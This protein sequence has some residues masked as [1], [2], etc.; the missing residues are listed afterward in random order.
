M[1][2]KQLHKG[3]VVYVGGSWKMWG[4]VKSVYGWWVAKG[5]V[6]VLGNRQSLS[7]VVNISEIEQH[8]PREQVKEYWKY[9]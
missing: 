6:D 7:C 8:I 4:I 1:N 2:K 3:D 9:F 5:M